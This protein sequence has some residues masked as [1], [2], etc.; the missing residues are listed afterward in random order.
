MTI[1]QAIIYGIVQ[2]LGEFLPI[3]SSGHLAALPQIMNWQDPGLAF[4]V[5]LHLGTLL[6]VVVF[7]WRDWMDLIFSGVTRPKS[8]DGKLF[9]FI[10]F[11]SVPGAIIGKLFEKQAESAFRNLALIGVMLIVMGIILYFAD[12]MASNRVTIEKIG[13]RR[14]LIIGFS[15]ALAIIPGVSRSG[16]T[17]TAGLFTGLKKEDTAKFSFLLSTPIV[18]GAG[19]LKLKDMIHMPSSEVTPFII[20]MVTSAIVGFIAIKFLMDYL[21]RNGFGIFVIYRFIVGSLFIA[22]YFLK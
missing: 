19:I 4:D 3:S 15:Q 11:A 2:G 18:F 12:K 9:W 6:A 8:K 5:A 22:I 14:S 13:L 17:M 10:V 20:G 7:F 1:L 21:K 16:V